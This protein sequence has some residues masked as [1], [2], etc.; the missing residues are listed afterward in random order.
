MTLAAVGAD[1]HVSGNSRTAVRADLDD[2]TAVAA[3]IVGVGRGFVLTGCTPCDVWE[4]LQSFGRDHLAAH[5]TALG[6]LEIKIV[7]SRFQD[8]AGHRAILAPHRSHLIFEKSEQH[9]P[10]G[11]C[12]AS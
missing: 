2:A 12:F 8:K 4:D 7:S 11:L 3:I 9:A 1:S 10:V 5:F 6:I